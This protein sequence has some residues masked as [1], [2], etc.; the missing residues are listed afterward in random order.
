MGIHRFTT[1]VPADPGNG[2]GR[3]RTS[4]GEDCTWCQTHGSNYRE[5]LI[6][7]QLAAI[8]IERTWYVAKMARL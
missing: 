5:G 2:N 7:R 1:V 3:R 6:D 4:V 8:D